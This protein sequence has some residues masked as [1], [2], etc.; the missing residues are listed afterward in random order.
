ML[1]SI[2]LIFC[3]LYFSDF[4]IFYVFFCFVLLFAAYCFISGLGTFL[5]YWLHISRGYYLPNWSFF[6]W[7]FFCSHLSSSFTPL[8]LLPALVF[9]RNSSTNLT[10]YRPTSN[11]AS[12]F[13]SSYLCHSISTLLKFFLKIYYLACYFRHFVYK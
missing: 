4:Y 12:Y 10:A 2:V 9:S 7:S 1:F 8:F 3:L 6:S 13:F 11:S 5:L